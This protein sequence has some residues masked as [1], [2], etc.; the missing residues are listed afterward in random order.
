[1]QIGNQLTKNPR[2]DSNKKMISSSSSSVGNNN[3][4]D[5][6]VLPPPSPDAV[7]QSSSSTP[8]RRQ[9]APKHGKKR[10]RAEDEYPWMHIVIGQDGGKK[11]RI[12]AVKWKASTSL[13]VLKSHLSKRHCISD[14]AINTDEQQASTSQQIRQRLLTESNPIRKI[15]SSKRDRLDNLI[16]KSIVG[17]SLPHSIVENRYFIELVQKA[18]SE[19]SYVPIGRHAVKQR[20][21]GLF[22][23]MFQALVNVLK[24][25]EGKFSISFDGWSNFNLR[26]YYSVFCIGWI[27][28][29]VFAEKGML[30]H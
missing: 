3:C 20:L 18:S 9:S 27:V 14:P 22:A 16:V 23:E 7:I 17:L 8:Q 11:C 10:A 1:M 6:V 25:V 24:S 12:C 30:F 4:I 13:T 19:P 15:S 2:L 29:Y 21:T 28:R 26:G 5:A